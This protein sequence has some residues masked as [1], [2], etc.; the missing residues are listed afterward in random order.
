MEC[1]I[2]LHLKK[3]S[4]CLQ[5][6]DVHLED[7]LFDY[8]HVVLAEEDIGRLDHTVSEINR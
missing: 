6:L 1:P 8:P 2:V 4:I 5:F 7:P 3:T